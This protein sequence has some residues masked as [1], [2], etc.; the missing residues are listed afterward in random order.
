[1]GYCGWY[2]LRKFE[3]DFSFEAHLMFHPLET[4]Y[5]HPLETARLHLLEAL[6]LLRV[7]VHMFWWERHPLET[8]SLGQV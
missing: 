7:L 3:T 8:V 1:M 5:L 4:T 6:V 2:L